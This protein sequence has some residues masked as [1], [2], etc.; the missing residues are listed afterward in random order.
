MLDQIVY[1]I[2][3]AIVSLILYACSSDTTTR[4]GGV[5]RFSESHPFGGSAP[6]PVN[7]KR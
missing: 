2:V 3:C 7:S 5:R 6:Q 1:T 4:G